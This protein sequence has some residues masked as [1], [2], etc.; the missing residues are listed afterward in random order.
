MYE[1]E[2][3]FCND[4]VLLFMIMMMTVTL[5]MTAILILP[6]GPYKLNPVILWICVQS[7][8]CQKS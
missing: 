3:I 5:M 6:K 1:I 2:S 8:S 7:S 4:A